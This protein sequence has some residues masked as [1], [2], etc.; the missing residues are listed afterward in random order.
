M[1]DVGG[2]GTS[3]RLSYHSQLSAAHRLAW[4]VA[5]Q[6]TGSCA[7]GYQR[8]ATKFAILLGLLAAVSQATGDCESRHFQCRDGSGCVPLFL[9]CD[10]ISHCSDGFDEEACDALPT[11]ALPANASVTA[12]VQFATAHDSFEL[13]LCGG[14]HCSRVLLWGEGKDGTLRYETQTSCNLC[15]RRC[16]NRVKTHIEGSYILRPGEVVLEVQHR[17]GQLAVWRQGRPDDVVE[18][19]VGADYGTLRVRPYYW[20]TDMPVRYTGDSLPASAAPAECESGKLKCKDGQC[21]SGRYRC[22]GSNDCRDGSDEEDCYR[23]NMVA[24]PVNASGT[25]RVQFAKVHG[26]ILVHL[27]GGQRCSSVWLFGERDNGT[28]AYRTFT[29]CNALGWRGN[30][31]KDHWSG[32]DKDFAPGEVVLEVQHR[33]GQLAVWRQDRPDDVVEVPVGADYGMLRVRPAYWVA[34][35]P[36]QFTIAATKAGTTK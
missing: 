8:M 1:G 24:L 31:V 26:I 4:L 18:V 19:P 6:Q 21:V 17:P 10:G 22:N 29:G 14:Q 25:A 33:P 16:S 13:H 3:I 15:G 2:H 35:M 9:R 30:G 20:G 12:R 7:R 5:P 27:C 32:S 11:V 23:L 36:V 34:D 28:L